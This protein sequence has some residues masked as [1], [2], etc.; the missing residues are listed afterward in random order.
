MTRSDGGPFPALDTSASIT[1][2]G[3]GALGTNPAATLSAWLKKGG[4][5]Q[6]DN[7]RIAAAGA[8]LLVT[9]SVSLSSDGYI[10]GPI[11]LA[12]N[13]IE[14]FGRFIDALRPGTAAKNAANLQ[15][16]DKATRAISTPEGEFHQTALLAIEGR[17]LFLGILPLPLDPIPPIR[18]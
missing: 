11:V 15:Q 3:V 17:L 6:I 2:E 13:S 1:A 18:F 7:L 4:R 12:Y 5:L 10:N 9:G 16:L 14:A 8:V